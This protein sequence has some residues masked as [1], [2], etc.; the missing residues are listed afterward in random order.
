MGFVP[1]PLIPPTAAGACRFTRGRVPI[2][3]HACALGA[4]VEANHGPMLRLLEK[5]SVIRRGIF[6]TS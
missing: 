6:K 5:T 4:N 2:L 1:L 3:H